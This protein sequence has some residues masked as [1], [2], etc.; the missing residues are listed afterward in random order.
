M[1]MCV[2][3]RVCKCV[4]VCAGWDWPGPAGPSGARRLGPQGS[5]IA[6]RVF[7]ALPG[8]RARGQ[9]AF[10]PSPASL[11]TGLGVSSQ[12]GTALGVRWSGPAYGV[13]EVE[14]PAEGQP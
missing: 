13:G 10:P 11:G 6:S 14:A 8:T 3:A 4:H 9:I 1:Q 12:T 7:L 2:C 5:C